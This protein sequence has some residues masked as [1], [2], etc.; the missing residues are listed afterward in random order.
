MVDACRLSVILLA[1]RTRP[2][3]QGATDRTAYIAPL[4]SATPENCGTTSSSFEV[5]R[6]EKSQTVRF[7][8]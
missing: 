8:Y 5:S 6:N 1:S 2:V 7:E 4:G 3:S